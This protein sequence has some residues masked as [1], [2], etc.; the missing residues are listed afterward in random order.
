VRARGSSEFAHQA[1][2]LGKGEAAFGGVEEHADGSRGA[3]YVYVLQ[4]GRVRLAGEPS[5][6]IDDQILAP[7][8]DQD[9]EP[10]QQLGVMRVGF[11]DIE[12]P[13]LA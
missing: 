12:V 3:D 2:A 9:V 13:S 10:L 4:K 1:P 11:E 7:T 5:E 6:L 8:S